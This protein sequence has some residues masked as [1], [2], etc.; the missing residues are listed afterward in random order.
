MKSRE[1]ARIFPLHGLINT[2]RFFWKTTPEC[3]HDHEIEIKVT[4]NAQLCFPLVQKRNRH[5]RSSTRLWFSDIERA[6]Y[7]ICISYAK[8]SVLCPQEDIDLAVKAFVQDNPVFIRIL[9]G[10]G[11]PLCY[12]ILPKD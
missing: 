10:S 3:W 6:T 1:P 9:T 8:V 5:P 11:K 7:I 2:R 12:F 4:K